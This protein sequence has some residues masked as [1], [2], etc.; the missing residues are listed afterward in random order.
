MHVYLSL[1]EATSLN[2][3]WAIPQSDMP[4]TQYQVQYRTDDTSWSNAPPLSGSP[5][6]TFTVLNGMQAGCIVRVRAMSDVGG[7]KWSPEKMFVGTFIH[8][9][10]HVTTLYV[11]WLSLTI[12]C[13]SLL[14]SSDKCYAFIG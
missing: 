7:G 2:V 14:T 11:Q 8:C 4:I 1:F 5:P 10:L 6:S 3:T 13:C 9:S 12:V